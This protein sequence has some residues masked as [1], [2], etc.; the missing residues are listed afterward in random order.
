MAAAGLLDDAATPVLDSVRCGLR[1]LAAADTAGWK[2]RIG[3]H[4]GPV[5]AGLLGRRQYAFDL[6]GDTVNT[7][8]RTE[9]N[10]VAGRVT[11]S[12]AAWRQV[13]DSCVA[14]SLGVID[15]K[16]KGSQELF[17]VERVIDG[18]RSDEDEPAGWVSPPARS[19]RRR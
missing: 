10:G 16:G 1:M 6:W 18:A 8:S 7:A 19:K 4:V 15:L 13:S 2:G 3:V 9:S 14:T 17:V 11:L 12:A 5:V